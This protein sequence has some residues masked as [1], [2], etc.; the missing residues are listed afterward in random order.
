M[1]GCL[2][3]IRFP[4]HPLKHPPNSSHLYLH[5][6]HLPLYLILLLSYP[7]LHPVCPKIYSV[8]PSQRDHEPPPPSHPSSLPNLS[9]FMDCSLVIIYLMTYVHLYV[10]K[11]HIYLSELLYSGLIFSSSLYLQISH[12]H[13]LNS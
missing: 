12:C 13:V 5:P 7:D 4:H 10:S 2:H 9:G 1:P 6:L 11:Y 3:C 8:F